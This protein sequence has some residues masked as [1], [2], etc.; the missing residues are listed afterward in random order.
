[1]NQNK[2]FRVTGSIF[3]VLFLTLSYFVKFH[4]SQLHSF[5]Q[6]FT[7]I[8]RAPL[9]HWNAYQMMVTKLGN[10]LTVISIFVCLIC[11]LWIKKKHI[12]LIW[13]A[14]NFILIAGVTNPLLKLFFMR[15][16]PT[17]PH[18][19]SESSY[20]FPSGHST[21]SMILYGTLIFLLPYLINNKTVRI[22]L[23]F[24][25]GLIILSVGISRIY[26]GVHFPSD[27]LGG[28]LLGLT[29]L[30]YTYPIYLKNKESIT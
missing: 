18:L 9:P 3:L 6:F 29:W 16:R 8:I 20:S 30:C 14:T 13:L 4:L 15:D 22:L 24:I 2:S 11:F 21:G 23:Q 5:D 10:P 7:S 19:V 27:V 25:L 12:E 1:M 17:L 28:Y 26:L